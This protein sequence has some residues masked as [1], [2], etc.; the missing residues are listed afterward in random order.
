MENSFAY[1]HY[2]LFFFRDDAFFE[3]PILL[4]SIIGIWSE[5][6][7]RDQRNAHTLNVSIKI[8]ERDSPH[9]I[10]QSLTYPFGDECAGRHL[11]CCLLHRA[12]RR[13]HNLFLFWTKWKRTKKKKKKKRKMCDDFVGVKHLHHSVSRVIILPKTFIFRFGDVAADRIWYHMIY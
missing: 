8:A 6:I 10:S 7:R 12:C 9:E 1:E 5:L 3:W 2:Y 13:M 4:E 11:A